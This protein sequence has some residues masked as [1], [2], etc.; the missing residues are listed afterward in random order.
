MA[1]L[2]GYLAQVA[3]GMALTGLLWVIGSALFT[4][5]LLREGARYYASSSTDATAET[6][7]PLAASVQ[8][9]EGTDADTADT[10][11]VADT[12]EREG[13]VA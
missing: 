11:V 1:T 8:R 3:P 9:V 4:L 2:S 7:E 5:A 13:Q 12:D 10:V 6:T